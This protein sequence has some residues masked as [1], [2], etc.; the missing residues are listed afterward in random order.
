MATK[1]KRLKKGT[2]A[3][4]LVDKETGDLKYIYTKRSQARACKCNF[5]RLAKVKVS[6]IQ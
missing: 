6:E 4:A 1:T 3:W 2:L 5:D